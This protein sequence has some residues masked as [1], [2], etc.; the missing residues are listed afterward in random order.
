MAIDSFYAFIGKYNLKT[1][2]RGATRGFF[3]SVRIHPDWDNR[4]ARYDA[5]IAVLV[6]KND[7]AYGKFIQP[8]CLPAPTTN[9]FNIRG[10]VVGYGLTENSTKHEN[11]PKFVEVPS[12]ANDKCRRESEIFKIS[13]SDR[14]FCAGEWGKKACPGDSGSG[15]YVKNGDKYAVTGV[16]SGGSPNCSASQ[17]V[18]FTSVPEFVYWIRREMATVAD[19]DEQDNSAHLVCRFGQYSKK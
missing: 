10:T 13:G 8:A 15:F 18:V 16:V 12:I 7:I 2:E 9:V 17:H 19:E 1:D 6:L 11:I 14:G 5:D 3:S 4:D